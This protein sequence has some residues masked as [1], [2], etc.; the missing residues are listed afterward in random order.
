MK[1]LF[2]GF[3]ITAVLEDD[4]VWFDC[5]YDTLYIESVDV[6]FSRYGFGLPIEDGMRVVE[7]LQNAYKYGERAFINI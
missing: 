5:L 4:C 3:G 6:V 7:Q 1:I 2:E